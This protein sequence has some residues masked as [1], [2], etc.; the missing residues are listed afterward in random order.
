MQ[1][2][3]IKVKM[4]YSKIKRVVNIIERLSADDGVKVNL[5]VCNELFKTSPHN[6]EVW[7]LELT[8]NNYY[9]VER[10]NSNMPILDEQDSCEKIAVNL[11]ASLFGDYYASKAEK[12]RIWYAKNKIPYR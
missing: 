10:F 4:Q 9:L 3:K 5:R 2:S 12:V 6:V 11:L 8:Y 7:E 1:D